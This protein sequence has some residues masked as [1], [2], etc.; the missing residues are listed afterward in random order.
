MR[1]GLIPSEICQD[2]NTVGLRYSQ[3]G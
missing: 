2:C 1:A 3:N